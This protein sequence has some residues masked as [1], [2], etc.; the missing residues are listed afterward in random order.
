MPV[1][2]A[3]RGLTLGAALLFAHK[4]R[5]RAVDDALF[6]GLRAAGVELAEAPWGDPEEGALLPR[7]GQVRLYVGRIGGGGGGRGSGESGT[8]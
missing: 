7:P 6:E 8:A 4:S 1:T 2:R 3:A 5:T